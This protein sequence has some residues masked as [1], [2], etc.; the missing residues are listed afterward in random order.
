M[1]LREN[2]GAV[3]GLRYVFG[4]EGLLV[5]FVGCSSL[6]GSFGRGN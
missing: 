3:G 4:K 6:G 5:W 2:S 1:L